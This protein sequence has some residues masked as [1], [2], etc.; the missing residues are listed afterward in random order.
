MEEDGVTLSEIK[1][2]LVEL[3]ARI[4]A[5]HALVRNQGALRPETR[6]VVARERRDKWRR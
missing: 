3:E 6:A 5:R 1:A 2:R 4:W